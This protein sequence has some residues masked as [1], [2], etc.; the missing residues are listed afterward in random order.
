MATP[1]RVR[2]QMG[3]IMLMRGPEAEQQMNSL[4]NL[5]QRMNDKNLQL[6]TRVGALGGVGGAQ[7]A[8]KLFAPSVP[9]TP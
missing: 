7:A 8:N 6:S 4:V 5:V 3:R 1:E 9:Q 2:D